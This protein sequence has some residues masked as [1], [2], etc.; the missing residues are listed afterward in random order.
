MRNA[1]RWL[2]LLLLLFGLP[3]A[4]AVVPFLM[5]TSWM[6]A[7]HQWLG[8]GVL[9]DKPIVDYLARYASG[10]S[11]LYGFLLLLLLTDVR[12]YAPVITFQAVAITAVRCG[13]DLGPAG[14]NADLVDRWR[15]A[16]L[17][18]FLRRDAVVANENTACG[19]LEPLNS[20]FRIAAVCRDA[21]TPVSL[22]NGTAA[23]R[24]KLFFLSA[25][26][27][28][29]EFP[30]RREWEERWRLSIPL[31]YREFSSINSNSG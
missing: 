30:I 11:A 2:K 10:F 27:G 8:M 1:E 31:R 28:E 7:V 18:G 6:A 21:A 9:P 14:R 3:A 13:R 25:A 15:C 20:L 29:G 22:G 4:F 23:E 5:P 12:R 16:F 17:L 26:V 19:D 24:R